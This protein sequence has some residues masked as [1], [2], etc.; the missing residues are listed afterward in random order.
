MAAAIISNTKKAEDGGSKIVD[1]A[2]ETAIFDPQ[3]STI[4]KRNSTLTSS[5]NS[6]IF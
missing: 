6:N 2:S 3:S 4:E 5:G 1:G